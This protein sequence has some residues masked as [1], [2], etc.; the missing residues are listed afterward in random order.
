MKVLEAMFNGLCKVADFI[1]AVFGGA[2]IMGVVAFF[3]YSILHVFTNPT[4]PQE[5]ACLMS[6]E[7]SSCVRT[8][9]PIVEGAGGAW[10]HICSPEEY[11]DLYA[12]CY[13]ECVAQ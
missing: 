7:V 12:E 3:G 1:L 13:A 9:C 2:A 6:V 11:D 5:E 4:S 10:R 8:E